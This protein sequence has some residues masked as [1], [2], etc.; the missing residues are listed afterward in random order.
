[1]LLISAITLVFLASDC[2]TI[3]ISYLLFKW[4]IHSTVRSAV[5]VYLRILMKPVLCCRNI[6]M[7]WKWVQFYVSCVGLLEIKIKFTWPYLGRLKIPNFNRI[8]WII[9]ER[10]A[11]RLN[12]SYDFP[13]CMHRSISYNEWIQLNLWVF[14]IWTFS[15]FCLWC[16]LVSAV[17]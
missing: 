17:I 16:Y 3:G 14:C 15:T 5:R 9:L 8:V 12:V 10:R 6:F 11:N 2:A 4:I 7:P 13:F 1:M